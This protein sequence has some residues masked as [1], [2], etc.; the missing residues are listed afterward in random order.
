MGWF[1]GRHSL[2]GLNF[3]DLVPKRSVTHVEGAT[4][5]KAVLLLPR[6]RG[7]VLGR[8]LQSLLRGDKRFIRVPLDARGSWFWYQV[9]GERT[10]GAIALAFREEY[11]EDDEQVEVRVSKYVGAMIANGFMEIR[12]D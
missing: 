5:D 1:S 6:F 8:F 10:V 12:R 9:D 11:P 4:P 2:A 7:W 3:L